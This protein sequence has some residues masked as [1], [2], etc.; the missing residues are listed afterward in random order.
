[1]TAMATTIFATLCDASISLS[2]S[3]ISSASSLLRQLPCSGT[4]A[5]ADTTTRDAAMRVRAEPGGEGR[6]TAGAY[7][8]ERGQWLKRRRIAR[9]PRTAQ[10]FSCSILITVC[11]ANHTVDASWRAAATDIRPTQ[12]ARHRTGCETCVLGLTRSR[13][14]RSSRDSSCQTF[15]AGRIAE[16][17]PPCS[18]RCSHSATPLAALVPHLP[19]AMCHL[20]SANLLATG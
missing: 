4:T 17:S 20:R 9:T 5:G 3:L 15:A 18:P 7:F 11:R 6:C 12:K 2:T 14:R 10:R 13:V 8:S 19:L 16:H 1:M